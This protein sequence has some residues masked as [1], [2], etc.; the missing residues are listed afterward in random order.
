M[1]R[2][3]LDRLHQDGDPH[4]LQLAHRGTAG[5]PVYLDLEDES[6]GTRA[7]LNRLHET[8]GLLE[9]GGLWVV[10]ELDRSLH[11]LLVAELVRIFADPLANPRGAQILFTT[12]ATG[13]LGE[14]RR[15]EVVLV[16]KG[17]DGATTLARMSDFNVLKREDLRRVYDEGRVGGVPRLGALRGAVRGLGA[18]PGAASDPDGPQ[19]AA[20]DGAQPGRCRSPAPPRP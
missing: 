17:P 9:S 8:L 12:H 18:G 16:D 11:P 14:L 1:A 4:V 5:A 10:D 2:E 7:L 6:E 15:D 3:L 20:P 13:L 19:Q